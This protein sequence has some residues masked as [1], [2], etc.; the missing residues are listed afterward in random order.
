MN[1][2][3]A[4]KPTQKGL[5]DLFS[6][7]F[8][9]EYF[10]EFLTASELEVMD[11]FLLA[12]RNPASVDPQAL[13]GYEGHEKWM[14]MAFTA[15]SHM[16]PKEYVNKKI[17]RV[18]QAAVHFRESMSADTWFAFVSQPSARF[19]KAHSELL[20]C[21]VEALFAAAW[22]ARKPMIMIDL[23]GLTIPKSDLLYYS[24][25]LPAA[26]LS[27]VNGHPNVVQLFTGAPSEQL[28]QL[29]IKH[30]I[31]GLG[32]LLNLEDRGRVFIQELGV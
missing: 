14:E 18:A 21:Y 11:M 16:F 3:C 28:A 29:A 15:V 13:K 4:Q 19:K 27:Y 9:H 2:S 22:A 32:S 12:L 23:L 10:F 31:S 8:E 1:S 6:K 26:L 20:A 30:E 7:E 24:G 25:P 5:G 17:R